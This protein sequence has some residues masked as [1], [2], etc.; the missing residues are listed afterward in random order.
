MLGYDVTY[1]RQ[2]ALS[3]ECVQY[4]LPVNPTVEPF[5]QLCD[6]YRE[7]IAYSK[8]CSHR[9]GPTG[10]DLLPMAS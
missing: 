4:S 9:D 3:A 2:A 10:L 5:N 6:S 7:C 1:V 8:K